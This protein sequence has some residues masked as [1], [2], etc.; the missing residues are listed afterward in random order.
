MQTWKMTYPGSKW[1]K[2]SALF[3]NHAL[4]P[5]LPQTS[6]LNRKELITYINRYDDIYVKPSL[7]GGGKGILRIQ[8]QDSRIIIQE[9]RRKTSF[10]RPINAT[11]YVLHR[12]ANKSYIIQQGIDLITINQRPVDFRAL[13]YKKNELWH[14]AGIMAKQAAAQRFT[15]NRCSGGKALT[16]E[17]AITNTDIVL[18][19]KDCEQLDEEIRQLSLT[20]ASSL[21]KHFPNIRELGL[22]LGLDVY[23]HIWLIEANTRPQYQLFK[24]HQNKELYPTIHLDLLQLRKKI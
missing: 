18:G 24:S 13:L 3:K 12:T 22:D 21:Q 16:L 10:R 20:I 7:G 2:H 8:K 15:T 9:R 6:R 19:Q 1:L 17:E 23:G 5:N 11:S 4:H 14:F